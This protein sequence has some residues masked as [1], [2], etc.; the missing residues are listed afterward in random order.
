NLRKSVRICGEKKERLCS[1]PQQK[2]TTDKMPPANPRKLLAQSDRNSQIKIFIA[3]HNKFSAT[4]ST[5]TP[6]N[7]KLIDGMGQIQNYLTSQS[8]IGTSDWLV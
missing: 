5:R 3:L 4:F 6:M 8:A 2:F 1:P 7:L